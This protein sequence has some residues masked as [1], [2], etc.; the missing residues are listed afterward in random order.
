[1]ELILGWARSTNRTSRLDKSSILHSVASPVLWSAELP[2]CHSSHFLL[3]AWGQ[4]LFVC[5]PVCTHILGVLPSQH[6]A[7]PCVLSV[8]PP[9]L[10]PTSL[11]LCSS[12][13]PPASRRRLPKQTGTVHSEPEVLSLSRDEIKTDHRITVLTISISLPPGKPTKVF[14]FDRLLS[15]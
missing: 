13:P 14:H 3:T 9:C 1:M 7:P 5:L 15:A 11:Q 8:I 12:V 2:H 6:L 10:L 4:D